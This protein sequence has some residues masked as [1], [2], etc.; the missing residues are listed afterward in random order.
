MSISRR[1]LVGAVLAAPIGVQAASWAPL[2]ARVGENIA[3]PVIELRQY[4]LFGGKRDT[5]ISLFERAFI[6][7]QEAAGA[8]VIGQFRDLDDPDRFVWLRGFA[9]MEARRAALTR[10]YEGPAWQAN[11]SAANATMIDSDNVL[12]LRMAAG[13]LA[14][15]RPPGSEAVV[16]ISIHYLERAN[17]AAMLAFFETTMRPMIVEAGGDVQAVL[18]TVDEPNNFPRLPVREPQRRAQAHS[19]RPRALRERR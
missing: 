2:G 16:R 13:S 8:R 12:L 7:P 11:R 17:P 6:D 9:D 14:K 15:P 10:F 19:E 4:T 18:V 3:T 5:L 1:T